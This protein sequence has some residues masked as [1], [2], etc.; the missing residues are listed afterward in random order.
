MWEPFA[1]VIV[2]FNFYGEIFACGGVHV[3]GIFAVFASVDR[4]GIRE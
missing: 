3:E 1:V 2:D 4:A